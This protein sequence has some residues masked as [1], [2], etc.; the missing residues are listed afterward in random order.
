MS[1]LLCSCEYCDQGLIQF[2]GDYLRFVKKFT[3]PEVNHKMHSQRR[4]LEFSNRTIQHFMDT[5]FDTDGTVTSDGDN[6]IDVWEIAK[7]SYF[8][9]EQV[10]IWKKQMVA[11]KLIEESG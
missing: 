3:D 10:A 7:D 2:Y 9:D 1:Q 11:R 5:L 4:V 6:L 8:C